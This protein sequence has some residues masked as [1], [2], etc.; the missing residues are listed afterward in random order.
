MCESLTSPTNQACQTTPTLH[1]AREAAVNKGIMS[2]THTGREMDEIL[3][4]VK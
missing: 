3:E 4:A 1:L 2:H